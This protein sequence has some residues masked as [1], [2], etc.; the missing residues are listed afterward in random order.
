MKSLMSERLRD[1]RIAAGYGSMA[2]AAD[3]VARQASTYR[4]HENGQNE[5]DHDDAIAYAAAFGVTAEWLLLGEKGDV[6]KLPQCEERQ[7]VFPTVDGPVK[8]SF[9]YPL[10]HVALAQLEGYFSAFVASEQ[11]GMETPSP[12]AADQKSDKPDL[13]RKLQ[14][15][16]DRSGMSLRAIASEMEFSQ[17]SSIQRY[18]SQDYPH[19][20]LPDNFVKKLLEVFPGKGDPQ[21][22]V[23]E[24]LDLSDGVISD[25]AESVEEAS[26]QSVD[27]G[28]LRQTDEQ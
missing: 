3:R 18:F 12:I 8:V 16:K 22:T 25:A 6:E 21:I 27:E 26:Q 20:F 14:D 4:A 2:K 15:L 17:A 23:K 28:R 1:A 19:D 13:W 24:I 5:F 9:P 10:S 7:A 11:R